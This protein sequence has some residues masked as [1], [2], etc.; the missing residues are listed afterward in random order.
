[1]KTAAV[2]NFRKLGNEYQA[3]VRQLERGKFVG[4]YQQGTKLIAKYIPWPP[5]QYQIRQNRAAWLMKYFGQA[6]QL[7]AS[8]RIKEPAIATVNEN[9]EFRYVPISKTGLKPYEVTEIR[10]GN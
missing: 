3:I 5:H 9:D 8:E 7:Y 4:Y 2:P 10:R 1:M 6:K